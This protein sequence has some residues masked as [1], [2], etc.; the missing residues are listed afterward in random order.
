MPFAPHARVYVFGRIVPPDEDPEVWNVNVNVISRETG[1]YLTDDELER[2][3][4]YASGHLVDWFQDSYNCIQI[5]AT[6]THV[7]AVNVAP[8]GRYGPGSA[9]QIFNDEVGGQSLVTGDFMQTMTV[10]YGWSTAKKRG[11]GSYGRVHLPNVYFQQNAGSA[12]VSMR[13]EFE[14]GV[15][16]DALVSA[17]TFLEAI[18]G[19]I[20]LPTNPEFFLAIP[21]IASRRTP[22][23][24]PITGVVVNDLIYNLNRRKSALTPNYLRADF[25]L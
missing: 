21:V 13:P 1:G 14:V 7:R 15:L 16:K 25:P 3:V 4:T 8:D 5:F 6:L 23:C 12:R 18:C 19:G 9:H 10:P 20:M 2:L 24:T 22:I 17:Q 11:E